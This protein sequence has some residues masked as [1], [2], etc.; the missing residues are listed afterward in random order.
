MTILAWALGLWFAWA[1]L[2][3][4]LVYWRGPF[5]PCYSALVA[6]YLKRAGMQAMTLG[7]RCYLFAPDAVL[8]S[9][10]LAHELY[11]YERQWRRWP[12]SFVLRYLW[13][14]ARVGYGKNKYEQEARAAAGEPLR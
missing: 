8:T 1:T 9:S 14:N 10:G 11:H 2:M 5:L 3:C 7:A 12:F 13:E 6:R 4:W